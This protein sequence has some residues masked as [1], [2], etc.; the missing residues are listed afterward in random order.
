MGCSQNKEILL[1]NSLKR[2]SFLKNAFVPTVKMAWIIWAH[3]HDEKLKEELL[4]DLRTDEDAPIIS[5][6]GSTRNSKTNKKGEP[7]A[8]SVKE[9]K[10]GL[11][12]FGFDKIYIS[13]SS[14]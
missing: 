9:L 7:T 5:G 13:A 8:S 6:G 12:P 11:A 14:Q 4:D 10:S 1:A 2:S 3:P